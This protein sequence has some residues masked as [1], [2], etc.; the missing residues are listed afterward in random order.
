[1]SICHEQFITDV[2]VKHDKE[3]AQQL[4]HTFF[5]LFISSDFYKTWS[6]SHLETVF[7]IEGLDYFTKDFAMALL[8]KPDTTPLLVELKTAWAACPSLNHELDKD[9]WFI[10]FLET[11]ENVPVAVYITLPQENEGFIM[12]YANT[13]TTSLSKFPRSSLIGSRCPFLCENKIENT[14]KKSNIRRSLARSLP[15]TEAISCRRYDGSHFDGRL[16]CKPLYDV[17]CSYRY[18]L[19]ILTCNCSREHAKMI[20]HFISMVPDIICGPENT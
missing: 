2:A 13:Y 8:E 3:F 20:E 7:R 19:T 14:S 17:D 9:P 10:P 18:I 12:V 6:M 16:Y 5:P 1:M 4:V 15:S 11:V